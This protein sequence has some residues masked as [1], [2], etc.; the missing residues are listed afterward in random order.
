MTRPPTTLT[1]D[2]LVIGAGPAGLTAAAALAPDL[3][4]EVLVLDREQHA[5][6]IPRHSD[7][8]GYGIRDLHRVM[9]GPAYAR[10]LVD[11]ATAAGATVRTQATVT[12][13]AGDHAVDV[14]T[15]Q[16]R[17]R[18]E[19]RAVV[20]ATGA[21]ERPRPA[22]RIPGDRPHGIYTTGQL[23]NTVHL[24]HAPVGTRAVIVGAELVSFSAHLTLRE[25]GCSTALMVSQHAHTESYKAFSLA[26][27]A[28]LRVPVAHRTRVTRIIGKPR[29]R[30]VEIEDLDTGARRTVECDTVVLTGDWIPDHELARSAGLELDPGTLGPLVDTALRTSRPGVFAA[31]NLLHPVDTADIA[32]LDGLHVAGQVRNWLH[33]D[34]GTPHAGVR[35]L[36]AEPLR[37][38]S[39]GL[40][41]PGD[42]APPR[43]RL[44]LW[45]DDLVRVPRVTVRQADRVVSRHTLPWPAA[46]GRV[47]RVPWSVLRG[48]DPH[49]GPVTLDVR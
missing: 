15:P 9:T 20:L 7:H 34:Q 16:G 23:Q 48:V 46:P 45:T 22:R 47:F 39:P 29:V 18:V 43:R 25:A 36:A 41:R 5:G 33:G 2:V 8:T 37:W 35:L 26:G 42:P 14:T 44:L 40:I 13:W 6:G 24:H 30:A 17:L 10:R 12:D 21:R 49:G 3:Q 31:G 27:R 32:A 19:A 38:V 4:G 28:L 11:R 1:P